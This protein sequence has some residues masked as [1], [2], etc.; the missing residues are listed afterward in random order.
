MDIL[1]SY[2]ERLRLI[3]GN[4]PGLEGVRAIS[5]QS[6]RFATLLVVGIGAILLLFLMVGIGMG[7]QRALIKRQVARAFAFPDLDHYEVRKMGKPESGD[8]H[9]GYNSYRLGLPHWKFR[10]DDGTKKAGKRINRVVW[11]QSVVWLHLGR[12]VYTLRTKDPWH[13]LYAVHELRESGIDI[14]PCQQ[15]LDKQE[16]LER[17]RRSPDEVLTELVDRF[18]EDRQ[19][20]VEL[21]RQRL[22]VRGYSI[23][24]APHNTAGID[25]FYKKGNKANIIK[26]LLQSRQ[27]LVGQEDMDAFYNAGKD[28]FAEA[29]TLITT[30]HI[31]V[32]AAAYAREHNISIIANE[33]LVKL[34]IED[35]EIPREKEFRRWEFTDDDIA[36]A[37]PEDLA[38]KIFS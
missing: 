9:E 35:E 26:C 10:N 13:I 15:E 29:Y 34:L 2:L 7:L 4:I 38:K 18:G 37:L 28:L 1:V 17:T 20:F 5:P 27:K 25:L 30:S 24:D 31:T 19:G 8:Y 21:C 11:E 14:A 16:R 23:T 36:D 6:F 32:A 12:K 33:D 22:C 3:L